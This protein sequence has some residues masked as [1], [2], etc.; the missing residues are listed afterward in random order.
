MPKKLE[1]GELAAA[2][3]CQPGVEG[4]HPA[5]ATGFQRAQ[6]A[7]GFPGGSAEEENPGTRDGRRTVKG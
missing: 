2:R 5:V 6:L 4:E 1:T 3:Q 7:L